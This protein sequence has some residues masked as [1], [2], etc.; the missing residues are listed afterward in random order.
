MPDWGGPIW[1]SDISV[2]PFPQIRKNLAIAG[3]SPD[4][5]ALAQRADLSTA[6][7]LRR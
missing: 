6:R 5:M 3:T 7:G 4:S 1:R 2:W